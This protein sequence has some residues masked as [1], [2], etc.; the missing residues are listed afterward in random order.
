MKFPRIGAIKAREGEIPII[1]KVGVSAYCNCQFYDTQVRG[2]L[3]TDKVEYQLIFI[4]DIMKIKLIH[5]NVHE[6]LNP[7]IYS[8]NWFH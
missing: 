3:S 8:F 4:G 5:C 1:D 7:V 2:N 6:I